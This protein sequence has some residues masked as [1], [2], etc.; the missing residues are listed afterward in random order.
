MVGYTPRTPQAL[1]EEAYRMRW[2]HSINVQ[3]PG[4][5]GY[6]AEHYQ[7]FEPIPWFIGEYGANGLSQ[8][9]IRA[10]LMDMDELA[11]DKT[12]P[13]M[14]MAFF[15]FQTAYFK[16]G[17][18]MNFGLFRLGDQQIAETGN[19]CDKGVACSKW[20]VFCLTTDAGSLPEFVQGR[21]EAVASAWG[22]MISSSHMC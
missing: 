11:R 22:G 6:M 17:S 10:E 3:T 14:G 2:A 9:A 20:P 5:V 19:I 4:I 21:A 16:G 13:F 18:E 12:N 7:R 1:M 8:E 15:Q